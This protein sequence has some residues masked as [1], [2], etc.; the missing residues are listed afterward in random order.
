MEE[1]IELELREVEEEG[2]PNEANSANT[3]FHV[4]IRREFK[5]GRLRCPPLDGV[6]Y[7]HPDFDD[8]NFLASYRGHQ[9]PEYPREGTPKYKTGGDLNMYCAAQIGRYEK[10]YTGGVPLRCDEGA[11]VLIE[12]LIQYDNLWHDDYNYCEALKND[13]SNLINTIRKQ[14]IG[15]KLLQRKSMI[16]D[17]SIKSD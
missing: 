15:W 5:Y 1:D 4:D 14:R 2:G 8:E 3:R 10:R 7:Y 6:R 17:S 12:D 11:W 9:S 16:P 13:D